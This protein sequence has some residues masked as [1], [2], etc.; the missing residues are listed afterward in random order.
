[1]KQLILYIKF[2][3]QFSIENRTLKHI[4][5]F[6][7]WYHDMH[8][9]ESTM[10]LGLPWMTYDA[11]DYIKGITSKEKNVFEWGS[12]GST[13]FFASLCN[14]IISVEHNKEWIKI[15]KEKLKELKYDNVLLNEIEAENIDGFSKLNPENADDF[16]S[17]EIKSAGL[18]YEKYAKFINQY[19]NNYFDII[20]VDGRVR[21]SCIKQAIPH[22]KKGGYLIV[23]NSDRKYYL[24]KFD[25]FNNKNEWEKKEFMGPVFFQHSFSKT[26]IFRRLS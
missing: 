11:I 10:S 26:T 2:A 24:S 14:Q 20:V 19:N 18:S 5:Q 6:K 4:K 12:G 17:K 8:S 15:L 3:I 22:I 25:T 9:G 7:R 23:D 21:N 16:V 1:M 13:I